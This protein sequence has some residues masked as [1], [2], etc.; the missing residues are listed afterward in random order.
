MYPKL[1]YPKCFIIYVSQS[2][3]SRSKISL[4]LDRKK[5]WIKPSTPAIEKNLK[6][7]VQIA[8]MWVN[9]NISSELKPFGD[10]SP[11]KKRW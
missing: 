11:K 10:D 4:D 2:S 5:L 3:C 6:C 8:A 1:M 9:Y 7:S